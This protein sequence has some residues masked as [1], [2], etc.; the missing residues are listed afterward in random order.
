MSVLF[1][2][3]NQT[4]PRQLTESYLRNCLYKIS[5]LEC[6]CKDILIS[7]REP[8]CGL[9]IPRTGDPEL[10][11]EAKN[12]QVTIQDREQ[13]SSMFST[14]VFSLSVPVLNAF[15]DGLYPERLNK[16]FPILTFVQK[17]LSK[18]QKRK[19]NKNGNNSCF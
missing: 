17:I 3:V 12:K 13:G 8:S 2:T 1:Q 18:Q 15:N 9:I 16:T 14:S 7:V 6:M 19:Q 5:L 11:K 4:Q 10:Y